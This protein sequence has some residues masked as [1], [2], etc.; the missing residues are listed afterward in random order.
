MVSSINPGL[1]KNFKMRFQLRAVYPVSSS[2]SRRAAPRSRSPASNSAS[3][4]FP[5]IAAGGM[6]P[7]ALE[8]NLGLGVAFIHCKD[9]DRAGMAHYITTCPDPAGFDNLVRGHAEHRSAKN[10]QG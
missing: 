7:L 3:G 2:S 6:A 4:Q 1:A 8:K 5:H 9:D 10:F